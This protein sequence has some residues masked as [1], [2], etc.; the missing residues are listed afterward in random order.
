[1]LIQ[2]KLLAGTTINVE[3]C[4]HLMS[5]GLDSGCVPLF[6]MANSKYFW[7]TSKWY[8]WKHAVMSMYHDLPTSHYPGRLLQSIQVLSE[9]IM[10]YKQAVKI[11]MNKTK[12]PSDVV[13][14]IIWKYLEWVKINLNTWI[15]YVYRQYV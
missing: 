8:S 1:M 3:T 6:D 10:R 15:K 5:L 2:A 14:Y 12:L 7:I 4:S 9:R 11:L 13:E